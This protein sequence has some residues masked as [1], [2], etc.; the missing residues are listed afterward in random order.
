MSEA[1]VRSPASPVVSAV[2]LGEILV[3]KQT[4]THRGQQTVETLTPHMVYVQPVG[5]PKPS[6]LR[7]LSQHDRSPPSW[8][9]KSIDPFYHFSARLLVIGKIRSNALTDGNIRALVKVVDEQMDNIAAV[10]RKRLQT[11]EDELE[12]VK[13]KLGRIWHFI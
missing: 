4:P 1:A 9:A 3:S 8:I 7:S 11:I 5:F 6:L 2:Q 10:R 12:D 13:R